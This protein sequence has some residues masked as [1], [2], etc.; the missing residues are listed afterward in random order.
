MSSYSIKETCS[1]GATFSYSQTSHDKYDHT[2]EYEHTKFL[3]AHKVCRQPA[4][5]SNGLELKMFLA[6]KPIKVEETQK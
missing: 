3:E 1:C 6:K 4:I 2:I 5:I